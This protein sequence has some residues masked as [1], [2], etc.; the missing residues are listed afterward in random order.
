MEHA[1]QG[2]RGLPRRARLA[3]EKY[4]EA[5]KQ[6]IHWLRK[7]GIYY[8]IPISWVMDELVSMHGTLN[9]RWNN[10]NRKDQTRRRRRSHKEESSVL[11]YAAFPWKWRPGSEFR[12]EDIGNRDNMF[13]SFT[14]WDTYLSVRSAVGVAVDG[15]KPKKSCSSQ[16]KKDTSFNRPRKWLS[17]SILLTWTA[18]LHDGWPPFSLVPLPWTLWKAPL[19]PTYPRSNC[20]PAHSTSGGVKLQV[21]FFE[22]PKV[23]RMS[24]YGKVAAFAL[25]G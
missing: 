12:L 10:T 13:N 18:M 2:S 5:Q 9:P 16:E 17:K 20:T 4:E 25:S 7:Q 14:H 21:H 1:G 24:R 19:C 22:S 15:G 6:S 23:E 11:G 3:S 8:E